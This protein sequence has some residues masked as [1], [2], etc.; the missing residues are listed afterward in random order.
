MKKK[1][2]LLLAAAFVTLVPASAQDAT[3]LV[4]MA[5]QATLK[6]AW[7]RHVIRVEDG[8]NMVANYMARSYAP[9][10][11]PRYWDVEAFQFAVHQAGAT[12]IA[13]KPALAADGTATLV[14]F[15]LDANG[16]ELASAID[17]SDPCPKP[18]CP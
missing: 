11:T 18:P 9:P 3:A 10:M 14:L 2:A 17:A 5:P 7:T 6:P 12:K 4:A 8:R 1:L 16:N 15:V 13:V